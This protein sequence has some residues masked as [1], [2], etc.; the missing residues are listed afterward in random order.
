MNP[1]QFACP[2]CNSISEGDQSLHGQFVECRKCHATI[3]V[4]LPEVDPRPKAAR[5]IQ[6]SNADGPA[7]PDSANPEVEIFRLS[8]VAR[9]WPGQILLGVALIGLGVALAAQSAGATWPKW[10]PLVTLIPGIILLFAVWVRARSSSYRLT[11]Q[12]LFVGRG[13]LAKHVNE[14]E[15]YRVKDVVLDQG[16]LQRLLGFGTITVLAD[17]DSTPAIHLVGV[18]RPVEAKE[19]IRTQYRAA[20]AREGVRATE[21]LRSP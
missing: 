3:R 2:E 4:P 1:I 6:S 20:R 15:L 18:A 7:G 8:P 11:S 16:V 19:T 17:D 13:W 12:R 21:F 5:I 9:A 10:M 14:L